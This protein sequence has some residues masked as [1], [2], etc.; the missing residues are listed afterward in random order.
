M[1]P[2]AAYHE[3]YK[4][5][6]KSIAELMHAAKGKDG[7]LVPMIFRPYHELDGD[8]FWWGRAHCSADELKSLWRFTV[9]YLRDTLQVHNLIYAFSP[10]CTFTNVEAYTERYPGNDWVDMVGIDDYADFGRDGHY[11]LDAGFKKLKIVH[12]FAVKNKKL[13]AFTETGL[14]SIPDTTWW[15]DKLL[16][17]LQR[18]KLQLCYVLVWRN[19][20]RIATH[21]YAPFPGQSSEKNFIEFYNSPYT[22]FERDLKNIYK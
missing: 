11:D 13:A 20:S 9:S 12:D 2:G 7:K 5:I 22:L 21:F 17:T 4:A 1:I 3:Q 19:D 8:W 18:E 6:L 16:A 15:T 14:E 10:D